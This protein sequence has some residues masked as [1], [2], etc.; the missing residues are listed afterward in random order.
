MFS[1]RSDREPMA[2]LMSVAYRRVSYPCALMSSIRP[3]CSY[4][5]MINDVEKPSSPSSRDCPVS[6]E[7]MA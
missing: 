6:I 7:A 2:S 4:Q 3:C 5:S 1:T